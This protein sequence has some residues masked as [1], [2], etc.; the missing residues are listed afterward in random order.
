MTKR[1]TEDRTAAQVHR[2]RQARLQSLLFTG[3][4]IGTTLSMCEA[5]ASPKLPPFVGE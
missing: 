2:T 1:D 4:A 5:T 3:A